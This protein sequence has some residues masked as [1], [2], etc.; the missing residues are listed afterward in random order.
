MGTVCLALLALGQ[1]MISFDVDYGRPGD[2]ISVYV[3]YSFD[4]QTLSDKWRV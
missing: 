2:F 1:G 4:V 3:S